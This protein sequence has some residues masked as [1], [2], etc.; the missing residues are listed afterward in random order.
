MKI[1][2]HPISVILKIHSAQRN[3]GSTDALLVERTLIWLNKKH[4]HNNVGLCQ[5]KYIGR[6][7][8]ECGNK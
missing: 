3:N 6:H 4:L 8:V 1:R 7:I 2:T 5:K